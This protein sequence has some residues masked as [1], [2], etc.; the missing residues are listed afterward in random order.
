MPAPVLC[1]VASLRNI[2]DLMSVSGFFLGLFQRYECTLEGPICVWVEHIGD[3]NTTDTAASRRLL[4]E[5]SG[6]SHMHVRKSGGGGSFTGQAVSSG[7]IDTDDSVYHSPWELW[8]ICYAICLLCSWFRVLRSFYLSNLGLIVSISIAMVADV[9]QF[10]IIYVILVL[11]MSMVFLGVGDPKHLLPDDCDE[12]ML[13]MSCRPAYFFMRTLF[14]SFGEFFLEELDNDASVIFLVVTFLVL[15]IVLMNLL[16]AMMAS[17][18][19][20]V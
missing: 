7:D 15:N 19:E 12:D 3:T 14:Q 16:I 20:K 5:A 18:Y 10:M 4:Y 1:I 2:L 13:Y 6:A 11:A 17:T 8:A 9:A